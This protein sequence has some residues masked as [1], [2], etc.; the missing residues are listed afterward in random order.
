[1]TGQ[2]GGRVYGRVRDEVQRLAEMVRNWPEGERWTRPGD[3]AQDKE[4]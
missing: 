1:M 3:G 4:G 2:D